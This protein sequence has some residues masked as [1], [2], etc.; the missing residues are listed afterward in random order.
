MHIQNSERRSIAGALKSKKSLRIIAKRLGRSVS[1]I[2]DEVK[3]NSVKGEYDPWKAA[4]KARQRRKQSKQQCLKVAMDLTLKQYVTHHVE[5]DQ[6]PEALSK[7]LKEVDTHLPYVSTKAIYAFIHSIHG[8]RLERHLHTKRVKRHGGRKRGSYTPSDLTK[9]RVTERPKRIENRTQFGHFEGDFIESG[10]DG[11]GSV[12]VLIER[13]TRYPFLLYT[14]RKDT[15]TINALMAT[16]LNQ[17]PVVSITLDNDISFQKHEALSELIDATVYFTNTYASYEKG[18]V[19][20]RNKALREYIPK[21]SDISQYRHILDYAAYKLRTRFMVVLGGLSPQEV[22]DK[23]MKKT[24]RACVIKK[25][26]VLKVSVKCS[27]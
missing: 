8:R 12:L 6:N 10:K 7:R 17:V 11:T 23:E 14:E 1:S 9:R 22:W 24:R 18:T 5:D 2:S 26:E 13:K 16:T 25:N 21:R 27:V 19:E 20:N 15:L 4:N 3:R